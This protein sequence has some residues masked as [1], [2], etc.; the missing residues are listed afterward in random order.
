MT[1]HCE[2][3]VR[4]D[5]CGLAA[6]DFIIYIYKSIVRSED[7]QPVVATAV[8]VGAKR[9]RSFLVLVF[10]ATRTKTSF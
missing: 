7:A 1:A 4:W 3:V 2:R 5:C 10:I 8:P 6:P 9:T